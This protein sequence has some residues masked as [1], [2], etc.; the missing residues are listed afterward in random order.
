MAATIRITPEELR[1][2]AS[3]MTNHANDV[4]QIIA[5]MEQEVVNLDANWD[6]ASQNAYIPL[7]Q[8]MSKAI[9]DQIDQVII[10]GLSPSLSAI[11]NTLEQTD[12][13]LASSISQ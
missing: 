7:F 13:E 3:N 1:T 6:G 10:Q 9:H 2:T 5:S 8:E 11:A 12:E 4:L